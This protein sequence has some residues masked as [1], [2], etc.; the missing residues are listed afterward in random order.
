LHEQILKNNINKQNN[1]LKQKI[2]NLEHT[3]RFWNNHHQVCSMPTYLN[4][5]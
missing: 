4:T 2:S 1:K 3:N 5:N